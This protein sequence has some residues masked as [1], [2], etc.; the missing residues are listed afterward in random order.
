MPMDDQNN[1]PVSR[2]ELRR[3]LRDD[4]NFALVDELVTWMKACALPFWAQA[5]V[6]PETGL[7]YE[8]M[9]LDGSPDRQSP[10]RVRVQFRQIYAL[11]HAAHIGWYPDGAAVALAAWKR[12]LPAAYR[13]GGEPGFVHV[14]DAAGHIADS[15]RDT[16]DHAFAV[17]A[18]T[19]LYRATGDEGVHQ[20]LRDLLA[21]ADHHLTCANGALKEGVPD[22]LP[23]RQNPQMHWFEAMLALI[24]TGAEPS[25]AERAARHETIARS[26]LWDSASGTIGEYFDGNW[27][28]VAGLS[29]NV[30]EPGHMAEWTWLLRRHETLL[31]KPRSPFPSLLLN[32][33]RRFES[34]E[35]GLLVDK[36][37]RSGM[38]VEGTRRIWL[39]TE[40]VKAHLAEAEAG[41]PGA[42]G[43]ALQAL[44]RLEH[45]Y[46]RKPFA[47]GWIDQLDHA[48]MPVSEKIPGS[49]LYHV[50]VAVHD[51]WRVSR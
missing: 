35:L 36:A 10:L 27:K 5:G 50:F 40:L 33:A 48:G 8:R 11:A 16:Y 26:T 9:N 31:G 47:A 30:I 19:W 24:E 13:A 41:V 39:Q 32:A 6:S 34:P 18:A 7:F 14:L 49:I 45:H 20:V 29:G 28:P 46:L 44:R 23:Y 22:N 43:L 4:P 1:T 42:P 15:R 25:A 17:L 38:T 21:F 12:L 2:G 3:A 51:V 37:T